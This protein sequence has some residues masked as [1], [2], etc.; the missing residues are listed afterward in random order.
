M[1]NIV[2]TI[3]EINKLKKPPIFIPKLVQRVNMKISNVFKI[4]ADNPMINILGVIFIKRIT[5]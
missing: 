5:G 1:L 3:V 2:S 4:N